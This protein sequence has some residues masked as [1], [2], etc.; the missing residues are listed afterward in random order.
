MRSTRQ[1][2]NA[3]T[4]AEQTTVEVYRCDRRDQWCPASRD[5]R[6]QALR[7]NQTISIAP[8]EQSEATTK[9]QVTMHEQERTNA[10]RTLQHSSKAQCTAKQRQNKTTRASAIQVQ[11]AGRGAEALSSQRGPLNVHI[12][13]LDPRPSCS[14]CFSSAHASHVSLAADRWPSAHEAQAATQHE[15]PR[16]GG[17]RPEAGV[18]Q[19]AQ[20]QPRAQ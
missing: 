19:F 16:C 12:P 4:V 11:C 1:A 18:R 9:T 17:S 8:C 15:R 7:Q 5:T 6:P 3:Q 20:S 10:G 2:S 13:H 14:T